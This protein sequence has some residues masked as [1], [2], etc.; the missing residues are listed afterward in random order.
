MAADAS[1]SPVG[2]TGVMLV[3]DTALP[4]PDHI[5]ATVAARSRRRTTHQG[6]G[7]AGLVW[8][9]LDFLGLRLSILVVQPPYQ[10]YG[11]LTTVRGVFFSTPG[12][13]VRVG[14]GLLRYCGCI[15]QC[16]AVL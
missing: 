14:P 10:G 16:F 15:P 13:R 7:E 2:A 12:G 9:C 11:R 1:L 6:S 4:T 8:P 3:T 5:L